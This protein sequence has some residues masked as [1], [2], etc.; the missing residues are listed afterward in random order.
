MEPTSSAVATTGFPSPN[1][2]TP[3]AVRVTTVAVWTKAAA[4]PPATAA[5]VQRN[6]GSTSV[7]KL[8]P[9]PAQ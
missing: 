4:P 2:V 8:A 6:Q 1:V 9:R 3:D 7:T 5:N